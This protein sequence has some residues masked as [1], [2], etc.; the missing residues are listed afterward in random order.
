MTQRASDSLS[1]H[2]STSLKIRQSPNLESKHERPSNLNDTGSVG[3]FGLFRYASTRHKC[4]IV[5]GLFLSFAHGFLMPAKPII[6][7]EITEDFTPDKSKQ[8]IRDKA[9][10]SSIKMIIFGI[11]IYAISL[12]GMAIWNYVGISLTSEV[13]RRYFKKILT[14]E[15]G[16]FDIHNPEQLTSNFDTQIAAY[17]RGIG[18]SIHI[19]FYAN[20]MVVSGVTVGGYYGIIYALIILFTIPFFFIGTSLFVGV[21]IHASKKSRASYSRA[22]ALAE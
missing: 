19:F 21:S 22:A 6:F 4:L 13:K 8:E 5:V 11:I 17:K 2:E 10:E 3:F 16:W 15:I 18:Q 12:S 14:R 7:G 20:S 1:N 9:A